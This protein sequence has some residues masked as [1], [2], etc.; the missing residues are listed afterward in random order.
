[1]SLITDTET[2]AALC[3]RLADSKYV[4][5]DTEFIR[6]KTYWPRLCL[7]QVA[8]ENEAACIDPL[9]DGIDLEPFFSYNF[10]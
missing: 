1:M 6:E 8:G 4:T 2:L 10:V 7:I 3:V 5:V 9:A